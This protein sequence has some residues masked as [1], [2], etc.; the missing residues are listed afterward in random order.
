LVAQS[1]A[2]GLEPFQHAAPRLI[3][4]KHFSKQ[5]NEFFGVV[6]L[7]QMKPVQPCLGVVVQ[8]SYAF[9]QHLREVV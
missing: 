2:H 7:L 6:L 4:D 8:A 1:V 5:A 3:C 9:D